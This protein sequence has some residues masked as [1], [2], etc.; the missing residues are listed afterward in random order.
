MASNKSE[1]VKWINKKTMIASIDI[2]KNI[3]CKYFRAP[4]GQ[5]LKPFSFY[6]SPKSY[7]RFWSKIFKLKRQHQLEDIVIGFE[8]TGLY[9][10]PLYHYL[11]KKPAKL[12][13]VQSNATYP[14]FERFSLSVAR[15]EECLPR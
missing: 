10:E 8:S 13:Q 9:A 5:E 1:K 6:N 4:D 14:Y 3:H 15:P 2:G 11:K 7:H 12:V